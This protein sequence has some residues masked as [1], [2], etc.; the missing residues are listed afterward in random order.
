MVDAADYAADLSTPPA[1]TTEYTG[2]AQGYL[3]TD[4]PV[5]GGEVFSLI[6][7]S[8]LAPRDYLDAHFDTGRERQGH[9]G[10]DGPAPRGSRR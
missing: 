2:L 1:S 5:H 3:L 6:R 8:D 10:G 4:P 9:V 7:T